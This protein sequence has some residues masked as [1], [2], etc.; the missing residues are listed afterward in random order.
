MEVYG[1]NHGELIKAH[2]VGHMFL[3]DGSRLEEAK[4]A[5]AFD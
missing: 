1:V 2:E 5:T 3:R 4:H